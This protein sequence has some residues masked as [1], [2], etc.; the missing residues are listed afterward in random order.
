MKNSSLKST[1]NSALIQKNSLT[2]EINIPNV[3]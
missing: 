2:L 3:P 1:I